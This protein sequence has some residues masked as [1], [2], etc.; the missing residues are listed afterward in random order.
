[1]DQ[2]PSVF[3]RSDCLG[4]LWLAAWLSIQLPGRL[5]GWLPGWLWLALAGSG[6]LWLALAWRLS[7]PLA[8]WLSSY[9]AFWHS[10]SL[11]EPQVLLKRIEPHWPRFHAGVFCSDLLANAIEPGRA[12]PSARNL[13]SKAGPS[14][15]QWLLRAGPSRALQP[16]LEAP[17]RA[18]PSLLAEPRRAEPSRASMPNRAGPR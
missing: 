4:W 14:S 5:P 12:K 2:Q 16:S 13:P 10:G 6:W 3:P 15:C 17:S 8:L 18:E 1:M 7:G 11:A 9:V